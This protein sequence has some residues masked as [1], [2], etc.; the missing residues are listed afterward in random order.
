MR[1]EESIK[2][3]SFLQV[4]LHIKAKDT[5]KRTKRGGKSSAAGWKWNPQPQLC[6]S[7]VEGLS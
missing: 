4:W 3:G 1:G 2:A 7:D 6:A 5:R